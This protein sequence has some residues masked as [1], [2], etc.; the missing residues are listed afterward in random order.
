MKKLKMSR[1]HLIQ[2]GVASATGLMANSLLSGRNSFAA[3]LTEDGLHYQPWF[4]ESFL[5]LAD[6]R[7]TAREGQKHFAIIWELKGC[8]YCAETHNTNFSNEKIASYIQKNFDILQLNIIGSRNVTDFDGEVLSE[9]D[10]A[11]KYGVRFTPTIQF[12]SISEDP[13]ADMAPKKREV[14]RLP[15]YAKPEHFLTTFQYVAEQEY[16]KGS[17]RDYM[18]RAQS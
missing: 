1:R 2:A 17:L 16:K 8:P 13:L 18:K 14:L 12:F 11:A 10:L 3:E 5:E 15:G 7:V 9:K 6:D 4:L